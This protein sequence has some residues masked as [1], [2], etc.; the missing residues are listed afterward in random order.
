MRKFRA[1]SRHDVVI[2]MHL[3]TN[4]NVAETLE[5]AMESMDKT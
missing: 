5:D 3:P 1:S 4:C 2:S